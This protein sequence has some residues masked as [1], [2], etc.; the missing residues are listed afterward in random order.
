MK[1]ELA[2]K[3]RGKKMFEFDSFLFSPP[4]PNT[5]TKTEAVLWGGAEGEK[6]A[7]DYELN[8]ELFL[9]FLP[10]SFEC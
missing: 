10:R 9:L 1:L 3:E 8:F 2:L 7:Y 4:P 5:L 6:S